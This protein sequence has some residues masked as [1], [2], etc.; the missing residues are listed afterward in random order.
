MSNSSMAA[1]RKVNDGVKSDEEFIF[2]APFGRN[3]QLVS[4][5]SLI[6]VVVIAF[7]FQVGKSEGI[8]ETAVPA[9]P[10]FIILAFA[11]VLWLSAPRYY[12]LKEDCL[13]IR[14]LLFSRKIFYRDIER[15]RLFDDK[16]NIH[17]T[18]FMPM[19]FFPHVHSGFS[20]EIG[21]IKIRANRVSPAIVLF[22]TEEKCLISSDK[23]SNLITRLRARLN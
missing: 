22:T 6:T 1:H 19:T 8:I 3:E 9:W 23:N 21:E 11:A 18:S 13:I 10:A 7:L 5:F 17:S 15:V 16:L 20:E 4:S 2:D 12:S 14:G